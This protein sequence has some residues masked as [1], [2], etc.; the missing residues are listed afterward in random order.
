M[1]Q[2]VLLNTTLSSKSIAERIRS[3]EHGNLL[4]LFLSFPLQT[5][6]ERGELLLTSHRLVWTNPSVD[7][8]GLA[9][10]LAAIILVDE[11][12]GSFMRSAKIQ[13]QLN[14]AVPSKIDR[15]IVARIYS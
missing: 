14:R 1:T 3:P 6:Y 15:R 8:R 2:L 9:L 5:Q 4:A 7:A 10:P 12:P 13:L 11:E